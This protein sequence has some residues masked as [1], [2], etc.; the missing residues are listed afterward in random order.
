MLVGIVATVCACV[1]AHTAAPESSAPRA[2]GENASAS[3]DKSPW[4]LW[5]PFTVQL[6]GFALLIWVGK[7]FA[8]PRL[9][10]ALDSRRRVLSEKDHRLEEALNRA[11]ESLRVVRGKFVRIDEEIRQL[12]ETAQRETEERKGHIAEEASRLAAEIA[13]KVDREIE[14]ERKKALLVLRRETA[15]RALEGARDIVRGR[16]SEALQGTLLKEFL[17]DLEG[18]RL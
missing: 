2:H 13:E 4:L 10:G 14:L 9:A 1:E 3:H 11:E 17:R 5:G 7:K 16:M 8:W 12:Q 6:A 15:E 18:V